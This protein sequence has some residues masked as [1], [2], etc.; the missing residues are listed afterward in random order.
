MYIQICS[1]YTVC[2]VP[3]RPSELLQITTIRSMLGLTFALI[4]NHATN[5]HTQAVLLRELQVLFSN[6]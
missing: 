1:L 6:I 2:A 3:H 4:P 5:F